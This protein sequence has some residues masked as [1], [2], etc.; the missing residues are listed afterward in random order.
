ML[1]MYTIGKALWFWQL[2][3]RWSGFKLLVLPKESLGGHTQQVQKHSII[4]F[5]FVVWEV[6]APD[7]ASGG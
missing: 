2:V 5:R 6:Q 4:L 3:C 7:C 1:W